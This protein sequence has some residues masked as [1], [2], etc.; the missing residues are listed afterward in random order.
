LDNL[1]AGAKGK[2]ILPIMMASYVGFMEAEYQLML[3]NDPAAARTALISA[4]NTSINRVIAFD[5]SQTPTSGAVVNTFNAT[6]IANYVNRVLS[7]YDSGVP[8]APNTTLLE[9]Q[10]DVIVKE[11]WVASWGNGIESY[12][13][14]RRTG[15]P[16]NLQPGLE[17]APGAFYRTFTYPAVYVIRNNNAEQKVDNKVQV[18]WDTNPANFIK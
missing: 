15:K 1:E 4:M 8:I 11:Y 14:T 16:A 10:L 12:N 6:A 2:G 18:F 13:T 3:E 9:T 5:P 17:L 7:F